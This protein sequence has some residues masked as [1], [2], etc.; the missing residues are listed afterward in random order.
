M[1]GNSKLERQFLCNSRSTHETIYRKTPCTGIDHRDDL[2]LNKAFFNK[3][4]HV[5]SWRYRQ[6]SHFLYVFFTQEMLVQLVNFEKCHSPLRSWLSPA[7]SVSHTTSSI[8]LPA[9]PQ[10]F[11]PCSVSSMCLLLYHDG[12]LL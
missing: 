7:G 1:F 12:S 4:F 9:M 3:C 8:R 10:S 6:S 2:C 5:W 11:A